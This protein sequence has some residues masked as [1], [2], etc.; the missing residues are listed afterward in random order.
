[1]LKNMEL[2]IYLIKLLKGEKTTG[3]NNRKYFMYFCILFCYGKSTLIVGIGVTL[4]Y[5]LP[6]ADLLLSSLT[7]S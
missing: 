4:K 6:S 7:S 5:I 1:M 2:I 3:E